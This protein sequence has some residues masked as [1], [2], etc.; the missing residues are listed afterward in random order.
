[1]RDAGI[2]FKWQDNFS[3]NLLMRGFEYSSRDSEIDLATAFEVFEHFVDPITEIEKIL[4]IS[5]NILF[6]TTILPG[7]IPAPQNWWYYGFNHGQH[8]SFYSEKT[9]QFIAKKFGLNYY[10]TGGVVHLLTT[11]KINPIFFRLLTNRKTGLLAWLW[12]R[13]HF[14]SKTWDDHLLLIDK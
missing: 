9:L 1:M 8:I 4:K 14:K 3:P 10:T 7:G 5:K 13:P 6:S 2:D 12:A 11:Q